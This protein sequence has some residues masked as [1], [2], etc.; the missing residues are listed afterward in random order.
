MCWILPLWWQGRKSS[1]TFLKACLEFAH[2]SI[3]CASSVINWAGERGAVVIMDI[4]WLLWMVGPLCVESVCKLPGY[5]G[6][7]CHAFWLQIWPTIIITKA[8]LLEH[9]MTC[10]I[11]KFQEK[12][13]DVKIFDAFQFNI[14]E[15]LC[16]SFW[17][18]MYLFCNILLYPQNN[19]HLSKSH[20]KAKIPASCIFPFSVFPTFFSIQ[21]ISRIYSEPPLHFPH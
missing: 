9:Q 4:G 10:F 14:P 15:L 3:F 11:F 8:A 21:K 5:I 18:W 16:I 2:F 12:D 1:Q 19:R 20:K 7:T 13:Y 17:F 6:A